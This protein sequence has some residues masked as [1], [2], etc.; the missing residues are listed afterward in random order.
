MN[1]KF[2]IVGLLIV[3][4]MAFI[5]AFNNKTEEGILINDKIN[6]ELLN[7]SELKQNN[8]TIFAFGE[9]ESIEQV[10]IKAQVGGEINDIYVNVGD[11]INAGKT[12]VELDHESLDVQLEQALAAVEIA[13]SSLNQVLAGATDEQITAVEAQMNAAQKAYE[14]AQDSLESV[15]SLND[16]NLNSL[17]DSAKNNLNDA[18]LKLQSAYNTIKGLREVYFT[19]NDQAGISVRDH[20]QIVLDEIN[21]LK[22]KI[23]EVNNENVNLVISYTKD[24]L[25]DTLLALQKIEDISRNLPYR[26]IVSSSDKTAI[27]TQKTYINST[28]TGLNTIENNITLLIEQNESSIKNAQ[29]QVS[30]AESNYEAA[31]ANYEALIVDPRDVDISALEASVRQAKAAYNLVKNNRDKAYIRAPFSG[32][33]S[34]LPIKENNLVSAGQIIISMINDSGIQVKTYISSDDRRLIEEGSRVIIDNSI[35]GSVLNIAPSLDSS[36]KKIEVDIVIVDNDT[37]LLV[38]EYVNLEIE[39]DKTLLGD[40]IFF[41]P[42]QS[43]YITPQ[44]ASVF[45]VN[46]NNEIEEK[47]IIIGRVVNDLIEVTD[48]LNDEMVIVKSVRGIEKGDKVEIKQYE[49]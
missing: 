3:V 1:K 5:Y 30:I 4:L 34:S 13:E 38:G 45:I 35:E 49:K 25:L 26:D 8:A 41:L 48:G 16:K 24:V 37:D 22:I 18:Y 2:I 9:V 23:D 39:I 11:E 42:M 15:V 27:S 19:E 28:Y 7:V 40:D 31:K 6:I 17:Y 46:E 33:I 32:K 14:T 36:T 44:K 43:I 12:L 10:D 21:Q 29:S 20:E 47:E